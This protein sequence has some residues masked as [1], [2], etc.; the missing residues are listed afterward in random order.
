MLEYVV[1]LDL[2]RENQLLQLSANGT[3]IQY[4]VSESHQLFNLA[5]NK[6]RASDGNI[7]P[8]IRGK[9]IDFNGGIVG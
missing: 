9:F 6:I 8:M 7:S 1:S 4:Q 5:V 3:D 2:I